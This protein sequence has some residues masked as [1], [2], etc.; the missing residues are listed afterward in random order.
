MLT[1]WLVSTHHDLSHLS[2]LKT[3]YVKL[4]DNA[5]IRYP[6]N[7]KYL[8]AFNETA[9]SILTCNSLQYLTLPSVKFSSIDLSSLTQLKS[10]K[11]NNDCNFRIERLPESLEVLIL[12]ETYDQALPALPGSLTTLG[13][14]TKFVGSFDTVIKVCLR[15]SNAQSFNILCKPL[16]GL[17]MQGFRNMY[18]AAKLYDYESGAELDC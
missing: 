9:D 8:T 1:I 14:G 16:R 6:D 2:L 4:Y 17:L 3:L 5:T 13:I 12:S 7:L 18:P 15:E 11:L 10:L